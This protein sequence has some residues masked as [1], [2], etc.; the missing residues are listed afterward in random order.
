MS[1]NLNLLLQGPSCFSSSK[2]SSLKIELCNIN[3]L[4]DLNLSCIEYY[5]INF[6]PSFSDNN[7]LLELLNAKEESRFPNLLI[8][9]RSGT[10]SPW[11]SKTIEIIE[12]VGIKGINSIERYFGYFIE[13]TEDITTLKLTCLF[14]RMTQEIFYDHNSLPNIDS[15]PQRR[16]LKHID[17]KDSP[18]DAIVNANLELGLA[19]SKDEIDYLVDFFFR[20]IETLPMLS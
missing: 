3:N 10:I 20:P 9:P 11:S 14:D 1:K 7:K 12:N 17:I 8:G 13:G 2:I 15:T 6:D 5:A 18:K 16:P 4:D 19:L